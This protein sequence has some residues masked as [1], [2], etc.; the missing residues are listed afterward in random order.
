VSDHPLPD[1]P[2]LTTRLD[3]SRWLDHPPP[4]GA[5]PLPDPTAR[6]PSREQMKAKACRAATPTRSIWFLRADATDD[7]AVPLF[8]AT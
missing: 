4:A 5:I 7:P 8:F 2:L 3:P 1:H 6:P